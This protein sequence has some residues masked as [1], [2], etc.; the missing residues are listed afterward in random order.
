LKERNAAQPQLEQQPLQ[1]ADENIPLS[2]WVANLQNE[3]D[4]WPPQDP[5]PVPAAD[6]Y[7]G[8]EQFDGLE[9]DFDINFTSESDPS[10]V[11]TSPENSINAL[12]ASTESIPYILPSAQV[13]ASLSSESRSEPLP[14]PL[15]ER[16]LMKIT[17][18]QPPIPKPQCDAFMPTPELGTSLLKEFLVDF[19]TAVPLYRP[20]VIAEHLRVCYMGGSDGTVISWAATYVIFGIAHRLRAM[21]AAASPHDNEQAD[22]YLGRLLATVPNLLLQK[23]SLGQIQCLLGLATLIQT[24][25]RATPHASFISTALRMA[26]CLA[27]NDHR[28]PG[29]EPELDIEQERRVFWIAFLMDT[30][31]SIVSNA[32]TSQRRETIA[33]SRPEDQPA[34][35]AGAIT[36]AEGTW[37]VNIFSLRAQLA[38]LQAEAIEKVLS[39]KAQSDTPEATYMKARYVLQGLQGWRKHEVFQLKAVQLE[40]LLYRSDLVHILGVEASYFATVFRIQ[41]FLTLGMSTRLNPFSV[42]ALTKLVEQK[43]HAYYKDAQRLLSLLSVAPQ[44]DIG[45]CW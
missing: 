17:H 42:E 13:E 45:V 25:S 39:V 7:A 44:G 24:S 11:Q 16:P 8:F 3:L 10:A 36:A 20:H 6:L 5:S 19:N 21:S 43:E 14:E 4:A 22:Y 32:P 34:D 26:Q 2:N 30:E 28:C 18:E 35:A 27:Y 1:R 41:A 9:D 31:E 40:Q 23:P 12:A 15:P 33:A 29:T 38:L 37:G